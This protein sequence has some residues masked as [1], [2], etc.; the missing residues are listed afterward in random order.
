MALSFE[1]RCG[2]LQDPD[3][4]WNWLALTNFMRL[5]LMKA[6]HAVVSSAAYR[7]SGGVITACSYYNSAFYYSRTMAVSGKGSML[8]SSGDS[9]RTL[10]SILSG[11]GFDER[12]QRESPFVFSLVV[13]G[14]NGQ[15]SQINVR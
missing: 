13:Y 10:S 8:I 9:L 1:R 6:A 11:E 3:F 15:S 4:L 2:R 12:E 5:S 14:Q 7:K